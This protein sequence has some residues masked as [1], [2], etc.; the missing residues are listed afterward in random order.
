M[1]EAIRL[2]HSLST[3]STARSVLYPGP[4]DYDPSGMS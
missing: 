2:D 1:N 4:K 3:Q